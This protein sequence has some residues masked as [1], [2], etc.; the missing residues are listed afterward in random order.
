MHTNS[1]ASRLLDAGR[2]LMRGSRWWAWLAATAVAGTTAAYLTAAAGQTAS[3]GRP[4]GTDANAVMPLSCGPKHY[5]IRC[6]SP[7]QFRVAYGVAP[8][9]SGGITGSG[10]TVV[11][12]ELANAPGPTRRSSCPCSPAPPAPD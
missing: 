8:L 6:Y 12:P 1:N 10:E 9:L 7:G 11:M 4:G 5:I 3:A 2:A